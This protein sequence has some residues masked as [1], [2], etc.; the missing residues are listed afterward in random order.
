MNQF[1]QA[2]GL[3]KPIIRY[4]NIRPSTISAS[5]FQHSFQRKAAFHHRPALAMKAV[6]VVSWDSAPEYIEVPDPAAPSPA[7]LQLKILAV[8]IPRVVRGRAAREHPTAFKAELPYDPSLDGVGLDEATGDRY[9]ITAFAAPLL[10]ERA[11]VDR[12]QLVKLGSA[13]DPVTV[14]ALANPASSSWLALR[15]RAIGG[16]EGRTVVILGAT[17]ASGRVAVAVA[18]SLAAARVVGLS[19]S[20]DTLATVEGL[21]ERVVLTD[22]LVLPPNIGPIDIVLDYVGGPAAVDLLQKAEVRPGENLQYIQVG[23]LAGH[24][25]H[26]LPARLINLKPIRIMGSGAGSVSRDEMQRET[27]GLVSAIASMKKPF[28][29]FTAP[30]AEAHTVWNLEDSEGKRLVLVP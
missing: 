23:G 28:D 26:V 14:A 2:Q 9:F 16:C 11:N 7:Q 30:L 10:A 12:K 24:E 22:P 1:R 8:G 29:V 20:E 18:H 19:R 25:N 6:R 4:N 13:A 17:S 5:N 15:C 21:D 27:P 3:I